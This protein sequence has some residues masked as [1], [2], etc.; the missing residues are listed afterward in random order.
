MAK[1]K[2]FI[3]IWLMTLTISFNADADLW[4]EK[5]ESHSSDHQNKEYQSKDWTLTNL[6]GEKVTLSSFQ[7]KPIILVFWATWCPYCKKL[8][9]GLQTLHEKYQAKGLNIIAVNIREDW[10][11]HVYWRNHQYTFEAVLAG[12]DIAEHYGIKGTPGIVFI[13]PNGK[14]LKVAHFSEPAHPSLEKFAQHYLK[15]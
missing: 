9:P 3:C 7:G 11:P 14:L 10:K 13:A 2:T 12:D 8:L 15:N 6:A 5:N 1:I 4:L